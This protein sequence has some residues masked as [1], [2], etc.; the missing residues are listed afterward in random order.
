MKS[1]TNKASFGVPLVPCNFI[2]PHGVSPCL[3][4]EDEHIC[5]WTSSITSNSQYPGSN[6]WPGSYRVDD[7]SLKSVEIT[8]QL[9]H[10]DAE[11]KVVEKGS[12]SSNYQS[13]LELELPDLNLDP[14][15]Y[16]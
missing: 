14:P 15:R 2:Q 11:Q 16:T 8:N 3:I 10:D 5:C 7:G 9:R 4:T 12:A 1:T 6:Y 13:G